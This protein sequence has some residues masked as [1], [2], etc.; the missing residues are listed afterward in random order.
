MPYR[1]EE[2]SGLSTIPEL[3]TQRNLGDNT[4]IADSTSMLRTHGIGENFIPGDG[5]LYSSW[6]GDIALKSESEILSTTT[7]M[8]GSA[9][10][11]LDIRNEM[12]KLSVELTEDLNAL[13]TGSALLKSTSLVKTQL[14]PSAGN[15]NLPI[16]RMLSHSTRFLDL[17][18]RLIGTSDISLGQTPPESGYDACSSLNQTPK[19]NDQSTSLHGDSEDST[20][21]AV[22]TASSYDSGYR[23]AI[24][25]PQEPTKTTSMW[26]ITTTLSIMT[27]YLYL[28]RV[29]R[30]VFTR[31]Y[32]L[33]LLVPPSH[34]RAFLMLPSLQLGQFHMDEN[35][36]VQVQVITELSSNMLSKVDRALGLVSHSTREQDGHSVHTMPILEDTFFTS[37]RDLILVQENSSYE[38]PL[39]DTMDRLR[40]LVKELPGLEP[41]IG[42]HS[43]PKRG[44]LP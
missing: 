7:G 23:T 24:G 38:M 21:E 16:F 31:L 35:L 33:I 29:Y 4:L 42:Q 11:T 26:D 30:A 13:E 8:D 20:E 2:Q 10:S 14:N 36:S 43:Y 44:S 22:A 17:L 27:S 9:D 39:G 6:D 3:D 40:Q 15:L 18:S 25:S 34:V 5:V 32:Q 12:L 19:T 37:I 41:N 28:V 1:Q